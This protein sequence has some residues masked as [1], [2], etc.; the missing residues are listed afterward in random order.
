MIVDA[1]MVAD[2]GDAG[3]GGIARD[4]LARSD[5]AGIDRCLVAPAEA[6]T[7]AAALTEAATGT[8]RLSVLAHVDLRRDGARGRVAAAVGDG[9]A[10]GL[11]LDPA[12]DGI[13]LQAAGRILADAGEAAPVIV[14]A[15]E[16]GTSEPADLAAFA[17][18]VAPT[19][20]LATNGGQADVSGRQ[21]G[22]VE[23]ALEQAP[24]LL[25]LSGGLYREDLLVRAATRWSRPRILF[26]SFSPRFD[27]RLE[28]FRVTAAGLPSD[29]ADAVLGGLAARL[30][31]A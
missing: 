8:P 11:F 30:F 26:G 29:V 4:V 13:E 10:C 14:A 1:L 28:R 24:N 18:A 20:V 19:P 22:A 21:V 31:G 9:A 23:A 3:A 5:A 15:G 17:R 16:P 25:L 27:A 2:V 7:G 6:G 12:A